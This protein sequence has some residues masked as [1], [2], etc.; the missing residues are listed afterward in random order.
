MKRPYKSYTHI[1]MT[2]KWEFHMANK[3]K[4][5]H[6][7]K[8]GALILLSFFVFIV[9]AQ[10]Q[11]KIAIFNPDGSVMLGIRDIVREEISNAIVN[12]QRY[13]VV[14]RTMIDKVLAESKFQGQGLVDESQIS[15]LGRMMGADLV[16]YGSVVGLGSNYYLSLKIVDVT[17]ARV[18][19][20]ETGSTKSGTNDLIDVTRGL[21]NNLI[22]KNEVAIAKNTAPSKQQT[23]NTTNFREASYSPSKQTILI[24]IRPKPSD[25]IS[26]K[27][28]ASLKTKLGDKYNV[29]VS[30][31]P[32]KG[33]VGGICV[34]G[35]KTFNANIIALIT[36]EVNSKYYIFTTETLNADTRKRVGDT[37]KKTLKTSDYSQELFLKMLS[38]TYDHLIY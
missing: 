1:S 20:Q 3:N 15:E 17:T 4:F 18:I 7:K 36:L 31:A 25:P 32:L 10:Q 24:G 21:A 30:Y 5:R 34:N 14:E 35:K 9:S 23:T 37:T 6:M 13:T 28:Y 8:L 12:T 22:N 33:T 19:K 16:C 29:K 27:V 38:D 2:A 11:K 26:Q